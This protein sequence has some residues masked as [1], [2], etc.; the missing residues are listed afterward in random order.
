MLNIFRYLHPV[1]TKKAIFNYFYFRIL[2]LME[3]PLLDETERI[4]FLSKI[5]DSMP[6]VKTHA[7][8]QAGTVYDRCKLYS[9]SFAVY[10]L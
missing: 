1:L 9:T 5:Q 10:N 4:H 8:R 2:M 3:A 7:M 6:P